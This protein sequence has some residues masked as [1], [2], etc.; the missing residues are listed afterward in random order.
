MKVQYSFRGHCLVR[1]NQQ[2]TPNP[3]CEDARSE[4]CRSEEDTDVSR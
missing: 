4:E 2:M 1:G 3:R